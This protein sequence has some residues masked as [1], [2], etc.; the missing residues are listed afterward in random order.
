M[1][2]PR[3]IPALA[4]LLML[5]SWAQGQTGCTDADACNYQPTAQVDD[6]GCLYPYPGTACDCELDWFGEAELLGGE[7][8]S[9][10]LDGSG[11][12]T[13]I[14]INLEWE[15][16][17]GD[18]SEAADLVWTL[19]T[20][21]G[22]CWSAGGAS[23]PMYAEW[24]VAWIATTSNGY[25]ANFEIPQGLA[26]SGSW[27]ITMTNANAASAGAVYVFEVNLFGFCP[28]PANVAGCTDATAC[29][30]DI[31]ATVNDGSCA[32]ADACGVCGGDGSTCLDVPGCMYANACNYE[33]NAT[34]DDGSCDFESCAPVA[35]LG[36]T[37]PDAC[38]YSATATQDD[39]SCEYATCAP[40]IAWGCTYDSAANFDP[41]ATQDDGSCTGFL[42]G[43]NCPSDLNADGAVSTADLL[44]FLVDYGTDC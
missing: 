21:S 29:N 3:F 39:G 20:P 30:Y 25:Q 37:Y 8:A 34:Q 38:N 36:C 42:G 35:M 43:T 18:A 19:S 15:N 11:V 9:I 4:F 40:P 10:A 14:G 17:D 44:M 13:S 7:S 22:I 5:G 26:G 28:S 12:I 6:G 16:S 1:S 2:T 23:C 27:T 41:S 24:P 32:V 31:D 33:V